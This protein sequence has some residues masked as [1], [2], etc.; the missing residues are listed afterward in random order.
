MTTPDPL[1]PSADA[2]PTNGLA[3]GSLVL[4]ILSIVTSIIPFIGL[5]A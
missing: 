1:P 4:G 5:I 2:A 3:I